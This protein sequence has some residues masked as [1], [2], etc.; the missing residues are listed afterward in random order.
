MTIAYTL[1]RWVQT[2]MG[3]DGARAVGMEQA[4]IT[5]EESTAGTTA[6]VR[7]LYDVIDS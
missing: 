4:Q 5:V 7:M 2:D 3:N 1:R 6:L